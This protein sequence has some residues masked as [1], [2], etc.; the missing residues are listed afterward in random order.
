[1]NQYKKISRLLLLVIF[2]V[3]AA[4][5]K[6]AKIMRQTPGGNDIIAN[7]PLP[8]VLYVIVDGA[9]GASVNKVAPPFLTSMTSNAIYSWNSLT[10]TSAVQATSWADMLTGVSRQR[11]GVSTNDFSGN[12][13]AAYPPVTKLIKSRLPNYPINFFCAKKSLADYLSSG[14]DKTGYFENDD[15]AVKNAALEAL[16]KDTA[17]LIIAHFG[18]VDAAGA[19][20]GYDATVPQYRD[21]INNMD[22]YL[23]EMLGKLRQRK[24]FAGEKWLV[25]VTSSMGGPYPIDPQQD[26]NTVF[27][28]PRLNTFTIVYAPT[29]QPFF[30]DRPFNGTRFSGSTVRLFGKDSAVFATVPDAIDAYNFGDTTSFTVELNIKVNQRADGSYNYTWPSILGKRASFDGGVPGW[31]MFLEQNYWQINFGQSGKGNIQARGAVIGDGKW[32]NIAAVIL[33]RNGKR[34]VRTYT[35]G[36]FGEEKEITGH[37]NINSPAPLRMGY[38]PGSVNQPADV[39]MAAVRIFKCAIDDA[40]IAKDAAAIR[41]DDNHPFVDFLL[42]YWPATDGAGGIFKDKSALGHP[43]IL[44]G[45]PSGNYSWDPFATVL[46][47]PSSANIQTLVPA[48]KDIPLLVLT[49][50]NVIPDPAWQLESKVWTTG[51]IN[52]K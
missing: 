46:L 16:G 41:V 13:L 17:G 27:S 36:K 25:V 30:L 51:Q 7:D 11:H 18:N 24:N 20:Y 49:W 3:I 33:S 19:A 8:K 12:N 5:N 39:Y 38:L 22:Q 1:M 43:F 45:V 47:P 15:R 34:Y 10:D 48:G 52:V 14:A 9:R 4:C 32:H 40:T 2:I 21:A 50:L 37:G 35:D 6:D 28:N 42:G 26:D 23:G 31:V 29:F 44:Q